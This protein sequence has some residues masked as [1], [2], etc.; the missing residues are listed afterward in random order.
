MSA[1]LKT[2]EPELHTSPQPDGYF[3]TICLDDY[4]GEPDCIV[5]KGVTK[6]DS[7]RDY[8]DQLEQR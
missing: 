2:P 6:R 1:Q 4:D 8:Y 3:H 7:I 5:G